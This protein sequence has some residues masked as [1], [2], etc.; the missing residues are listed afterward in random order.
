MRMKTF[1]RFLIL[2][3]LILISNQ[4]ISE[5]PD[6]DLDPAD[7]AEYNLNKLKEQILPKSS[8]TTTTKETP[9]S[10]AQIER[11]ETTTSTESAVVNETQNAETQEPTESEITEQVPTEKVDITNSTTVSDLTDAEIE[12]STTRKSTQRESVMNI[13]VDSGEYKEFIVEKSDDKNAIQ[14][15]NVTGVKKSYQIELFLDT[16]NHFID[17][18]QCAIFMNDINAECLLS[19][20]EILN[21]NFVLQIKRFLLPTNIKIKLRLVLS[22]CDSISRMRDI[23]FE[24][25]LPSIYHNSDHD[26]IYRIKN[27]D[28]VKNMLM[29]N[30]LAFPVHDD[31]V[32][33][34]SMHVSTTNNI[35]NKDEYYTQAVFESFDSLK[36][37]DQGILIGSKYV[38]LKLINCFENNEPIQV[39]IDSIRR[40]AKEFK[41]T[42]AENKYYHRLDSSLITSPKLDSNLLFELD[43]KDSRN[44]ITFKLSEYKTKTVCDNNV[45]ANSS[46]I[47]VYGMNQF[48]QMYVKTFS[49]CKFDNSLNELRG[50]RKVYV[51]L[52]REPFH[53]SLNKVPDN[54]V[55]EFNL[56]IVKSNFF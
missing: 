53:P 42:E 19:Y 33:H 35:N 56:K 15:F 54:F 18:Q 46:K 39:K 27:L 16:Q 22:G 23:D 21:H 25:K 47:I 49:V 8:T 30:I 31:R 41:M 28:P 37:F 45:E 36:Q 9:T 43:N 32:C 20:I 11:D 10:P 14:I 26:C 44:R 51:Q 13:I 52:K 29:L 40:S 6:E 17:F 48:N 2:T 3:S 55:M 24:D 50:F 12:E 38:L 1:L 5:L 4:Q 7:I 34:A